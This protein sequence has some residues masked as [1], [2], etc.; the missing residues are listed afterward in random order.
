MFKFQV[1]SS[2]YLPVDIYSGCDKPRRSGTVAAQRHEPQGPTVTGAGS[3]G[4]RRRG[5]HSPSQWLRSLGGPAGGPLAGSAL[6]A[7]G[8]EPEPERPG[9]SRAGPGRRTTTA[10]LTRRRLPARRDS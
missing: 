9:P 10:G 6:S 5:G 8:S 2:H 7:S 1:C 4:R 3:E